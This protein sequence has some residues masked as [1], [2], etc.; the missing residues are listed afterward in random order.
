MPQRKNKAILIRTE[1]EEIQSFKKFISEN[2]LSTYAEGL[3]R[4]QTMVG[5]EVFLEYL[6]CDHFGEYPLD[7]K[8]FVTCDRSGKK[9]IRKR[10]DCQACAHY[11]VIK[12]LMQSRVKIEQQNSELQRKLSETQHKLGDLKTEIGKRTTELE[13]IENLSKM[14]EQLKKKDKA[15]ADLKRADQEKNKYIDD[16]CKQLETPQTVPPS[17][18][19][20][21]EN[22]SE[23]KTPIAAPSQKVEANKA[24][25]TIQRVTEKEKTVEK[26]RIVETVTSD[27]FTNQEIKCP[28]TGKWMD[29]IKECKKSCKD[30]WECPFLLEINKGTVPLGAQI[31]LRQ[32]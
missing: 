18:L 22:L 3:K 31:R 16:L 13:N 30:A 29:I 32:S 25:Q 19:E 7:S 17:V 10:E 6:N 12:V 26:E 24:T 21:V 8:H 23:Q 5:S 9:V 20:V 28:L 1:E 14:P 2:K 15:I 4:Y 11:R 27:P